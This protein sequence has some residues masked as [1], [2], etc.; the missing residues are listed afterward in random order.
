MAERVKGF[1]WVLTRWGGV[2]EWQVARWDGESWAICGW[3]E[4]ELDSEFLQI[5]ERPI[6]RSE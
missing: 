6:K 2:T 1:Y 5:D 3:D 4:R